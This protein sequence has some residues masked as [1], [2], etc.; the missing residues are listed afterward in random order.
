[1]WNGGANYCRTPMG[2]G[3]ASHR[4]VKVLL[5]DVKFTGMNGK[6]F[7]ELTDFLYLLPGQYLKIGKGGGGFSS[8]FSTVDY[9][10]SIP[11]F[12]VAKHLSL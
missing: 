9:I 3:Q 11:S 10:A 12:A 4:S 8:F 5:I 6:M 1:M 7:I 2:H